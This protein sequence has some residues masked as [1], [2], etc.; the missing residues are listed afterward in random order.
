MQK[1]GV[2]NFVRQLKDRKIVPLNMLPVRGAVG[3]DLRR[4][5]LAG[6]GLEPVL[7]LRKRGTFSGGK[8]KVG[9]QVIP[10][11]EPALDLEPLY[12]IENRL[13]V[14]RL[15]KFPQLLRRQP[16]GDLPIIG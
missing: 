10:D 15:H 5:P 11:A 4:L 12:R 6:K 1:H 14:F 7:N 3:F 9:G 13:P 2:L 8:K 16:G